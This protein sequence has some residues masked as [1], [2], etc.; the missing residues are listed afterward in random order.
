[1][2]VRAE[3]TALEKF[4][5][6][7]RGLE[8]L[9]D[10][11]GCEARAKELYDLMSRENLLNND[12]YLSEGAR[13]REDLLKKSSEDSLSEVLMV[14][15]LAESSASLQQNSKD[16]LEIVAKRMFGNNNK[17]S[18]ALAVFSSSTVSLGQ[19]LAQIVSTD[20]IDIYYLMRLCRFLES[21]NGDL[22]A[23]N[24]L[25]EFAER[26]EDWILQLSE[27]A[28]SFFAATSATVSSKSNNTI[29]DTHALPYLPK[30]RPAS[31]TN[32]KGEY[33]RIAID[34]KNARMNRNNEA[35]K[36]V[37]FYYHGPGQRFVDETFPSLDVDV[38][39]SKYL[40]RQP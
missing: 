23:E 11:P 1:M 12:L 2:L 28:R 30:S 38:A 15:D 16:A 21:E 36:A 6:F 20:N 24:R 34:P 3:F 13:L 18:N 37:S 7:Q 25:D 27:S 19:R 33:I 22:L 29:S 39:A 40:A 17:N 8:F 26:A 5:L 14:P 10:K 35:N 4:D 9:L 32:N 31:A